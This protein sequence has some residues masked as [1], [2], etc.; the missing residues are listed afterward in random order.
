M[1]PRLVPRRLVGLIAALATGASLRGRRRDARRRRR[2]V[3]RRG[4][5]R[6]RA[7]TRRPGPTPTSGTSTGPATRGSRASP[8]TSRSTWAARSSFKIKTDRRAYT[9][10]IYRT[11]LVRGRRRAQDHVGRPSPSLPQTQPQCVTDDATEHLRLRQLGG[12]GQLGRAVDRGLRA[13]TSPRLTT[14]RHGRHEPHHVRRAQRRE[15]VRRLV[16][17]LR[18]DVARVQ[19][20]RRLELLPGRRRRA[21]LQAQLQPAV[22]HARRRA[23]AATSTSAPSTRWCASSSATGTT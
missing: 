16:P 20:V 10:D 21:R 23:A 12:L 7:R 6:R 13:S 11:G 4:Q 15:H 1:S 19:H 9:I 3:R 2:P 8:P 14:P 17:D 18:H 5:P 22:R